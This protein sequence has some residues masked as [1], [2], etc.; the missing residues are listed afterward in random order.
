MKD[1][2][3]LKEKHAQPNFMIGIGYVDTLIEQLQSEIDKRDRA[4]EVAKRE[5]RYYSDK[6]VYNTERFG[7]D[8]FYPPCVSEHEAINALKEID[9]ILKGGDGE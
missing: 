7:D 3:E 2:Q 4:L 6:E 8:D 1:W 5:L 9:N